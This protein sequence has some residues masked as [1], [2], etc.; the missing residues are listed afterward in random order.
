MIPSPELTLL[1]CMVKGQVEELRS[2]L[3]DPA[4][5]ATGFLRFAYRHQLGAYAYAALRQMGLAELLP[6]NLRAA[7][8]A[9][10][11][12]EGTRIERLVGLLREIAELVDSA[13]VKVL[14]I[15]GPLLAHRYY[16]T[17][18]ARGISDLD[19]LLHDSD[20]L[21]RVE[22]LLFSRGFEPAFRILVSRGLTLRFAHHFEYRRDDLPVDVHWVLQRHFTFALDHERIWATAVRIPMEG[23]TYRATSDEYEL[24]LQILGVIT[25]LQVGKLTLRPVVDIYQILKAVDGTLDWSQFLSRREP[26]RIL[27]PSAYVLAL[28]LDVMDCGDEFAELASLLEA[29][30]GTLPPTA[31]AFRAIMHS[32]PLDFRQKLLALRI[33][34][35]SL[36]ATLSWWLL[37]LPFRLSVYGL[38]RRRF[39][40]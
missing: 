2:R 40:A 8:K 35:S 7:A 20:D 32:R 5:D 15:K 24:V 16:G 34:E 29:R 4:T 11:L 26:E 13:G 19:I 21:P 3:A 33:Y 36:P 25:D 1:R 22:K 27:R 39:G 17:I 10:S 31:P 6:R 23:R 9:S 28:A 14:F 30:T 18:E 38:T 37:S 12:R